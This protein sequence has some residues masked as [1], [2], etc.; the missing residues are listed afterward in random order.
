MNVRIRFERLQANFS[1]TLEKL[2]IIVYF[3]L[4][5]QKCRPVLAL[6][7]TELLTL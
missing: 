2:E 7:A 4:K 6:L 1:F 3:Q 5:A